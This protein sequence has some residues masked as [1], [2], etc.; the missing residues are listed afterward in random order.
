MMVWCSAAGECRT[1]GRST[2]NDAQGSWLR[3]SVCVRTRAHARVRV[4]VCV[5]VC[6]RACLYVFVCVCA[7][8]KGGAAHV[9]SAVPGHSVGSDMTW[10]CG[11]SGHGV[12]S[13]GRRRTAT[14]LVFPQPTTPPAPSSPSSPRPSLAL[15]NGEE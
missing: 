14:P 12:G 2:E 7:D 1:R 9:S 8:Y 4:C 11:D 13:A 10:R 6:V 15:V 3:V 5:R